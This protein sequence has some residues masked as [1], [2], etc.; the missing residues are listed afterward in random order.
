MSTSDALET[1]IKLAASPAMLEALREHPLLAGPDRV[2]RL[3]TTY[4]DTADRRLQSAGAS[5]RLRANGKR[6]E[7]TIKLPARTD[8]I[9]VRGVW[10]VAAIGKAPDIGK[11]APE[12][13][14][15][16]ERLLDGEGVA[17][18]AETRIDRTVRQVTQRAAA[19]EIAF[20]RG[21]IRAGTRE[22]AVCELELEL[23]AGSL[24]DL[25]DLALALP[26]GPDLQWSV[27]SKSG[28]ALALADGTV[29]AAAHATPAG[30][31]RDIDAG[32]GFQAIAWSCLSHLLE[33]APLV[34]STGDPEALHQCRVAIR[35]LRA[36]IGLFGPLFANDAQSEVLNAELMAA[37]NAL[38][39]ARDA[40][41]LLERLA[42]VPASEGQDCAE[43]LAHVRSMAE[44]AMQSAQAFLAGAEFQRL[45]FAFTLWVERG[46]WLEQDCSAQLPQFAAKALRKRRRKIRRMGSDPAAMAADERH[47]LR[48]AVKKLRY[49][50]DFLAPLYPANQAA[51]D[52]RRFKALAAKVQDRLGELHDLDVLAEVVLHFGNDAL[53]AGLEPIAAARLSA[54]LEALL[55]ALSAS[56]GKLLKRA[57]R[58]VTRLDAARSWW[59]ADL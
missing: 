16:I 27:A 3:V 2:D 54:Q 45:L 49:A 4:F 23:V 5:L 12:P 52:L 36:G 40:H 1:E 57:A 33:N 28:R 15:A 30:V 51:R 38:G 20:D 14:A 31:S 39:P 41:V 7:Q 37:A 47:A 24:A 59:K 22:A 32:R 42:A 34:I 26:L 56:H 55:P 10:T 6:R 46:D 25:V 17:P 35:R 53:F 44:Q 11:F 18:L 21:T 58:S 48:I 8:S 9:V 29:P 19:I 43:L 50:A 13:R